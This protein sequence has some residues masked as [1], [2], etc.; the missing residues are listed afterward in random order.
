MANIFV[1]FHDRKSSSRILKPPGG[2]T[3]DIFNTSATEKT[4]EHST[5]F[6]GIMPSSPPTTEDISRPLNG[7]E[8]KT[9]LEEKEINLQNGDNVSDNTECPK[10]ETLSI[11]DGNQSEETQEKYSEEKKEVEVN[12]TKT[13]SISS[14]IHENQQK[15]VKVTT[16]ERKVGQRVPPGGYSS[17]L[18]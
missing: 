3:S 5:P 15:E 7:T 9:P 14:I 4:N 17:G 12:N 1:G 18:W 13:E 2:G 16:P 6:V 11:V 10:I 8:N